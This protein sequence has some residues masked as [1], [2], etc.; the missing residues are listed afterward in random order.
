M[1]RDAAATLAGLG[2][3]VTQIDTGLLTPQQVAGQI[4]DT[5]ASRCASLSD[6]G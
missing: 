6:H 4:A 5:L 2:V 3:P 1:Y